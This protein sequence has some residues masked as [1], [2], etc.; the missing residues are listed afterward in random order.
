MKRFTTALKP[1]VEVNIAHLDEPAGPTK[2]GD[3]DVLIVTE[4]TKSAVG[5]IND[6]RI[7][8][9]LPPLHDYI[10]GMI[11]ETNMKLSST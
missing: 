10:V 3:Y 1:C 11:G 4:E 5:F 2:D 9:S 7:G 6:L 8:H